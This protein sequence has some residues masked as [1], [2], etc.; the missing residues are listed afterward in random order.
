MFGTPS[1][2]SRTAT[3]GGSASAARRKEGDK[4]GQW[5]AHVAKAKSSLSDAI[6]SLQHFAPPASAGNKRAAYIAIAG[7][8]REF[9]GSA[10]APGGGVHSPQLANDA[11]QVI[12]RETVTSL[13][14]SLVEAVSQKTVSPAA[15]EQTAPVQPVPKPKPATSS[16]EVIL[17]KA[18][19]THVDPLQG[20]SEEEISQKAATILREQNPAQFSPGF[21]F[22]GVRKLGDGRVVLKACTEAE[23]GIIR[24]L[25]PEWASTLADG[26]QLF[27]PLVND[28]TNIR[29]LHGLSDHHIAKSASSLVVSLSREASADHLVRHGTSVLGKL[30]RTDHF[31]QSPLQC[32]HCQAWNHIS[33]C[34][35]CQGPHKS[36][37]NACPVK[38]QCLAEHL[39]HHHASKIQSDPSVPMRAGGRAL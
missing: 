5:K 4:F 3:A 7:V 14:G 21:C 18:K 30:C 11:V 29:W 19:G 2:S 12:V 38:Q 32:Y 37:D 10:G 35:N 17:T 26:M 13:L 36:F 39:A 27:I 15:K 33:S 9:A 31:I 25:G 20:L 34:A 24:E 22:H 1:A 16:L 6:E 8:L 28:I 23:A